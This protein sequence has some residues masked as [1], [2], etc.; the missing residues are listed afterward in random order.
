MIR[1]KVQKIR[2]SGILSLKN[3]KRSSKIENGLLI[4]KKNIFKVENPLQ[5]K[6][7]KYHEILIFKILIFQFIPDNTIQ[8][9][10]TA[11]I[12]LFSNFRDYR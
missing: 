8:S 3:F 6:M 7:T 9:E 1:C 11:G 4:F 2:L 12:R 5:I 10:L